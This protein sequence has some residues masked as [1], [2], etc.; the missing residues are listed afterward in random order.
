MNDKLNN[1]LKLE[2]SKYY[3]LELR[4]TDVQVQTY[5][6]AIIIN[7]I[8]ELRYHL[9]YV[10]IFKVE[11]LPNTFKVRTVSKR[12]QLCVVKSTTAWFRV[13]Y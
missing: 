7:I 10:Y 13:S 2:Y 9:E 4:Y 3:L 12:Y 5:K 6:Q 1:Y 8:L 11:Q